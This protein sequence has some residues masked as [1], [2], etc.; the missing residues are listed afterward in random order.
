M[1]YGEIIND[2]DH[3]RDELYEHFYKYFNNPTMFKIKDIN[4]YSMYITKVHCLLNNNFR[5]IIVFV[6][7]DNEQVMN[8]QQLSQLKWENIQTRTLEDYHN[9][10]QHKY[11]PTRN[12]ELYT[13]IQRTLKDVDKSVYSCKK[14]PLLITL[15]HNK[16]GANQYQDTGNVVTALETYNTLVSIQNVEI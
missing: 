13:P 16:G 3:E 8:Q 9:I 7:K 4:D 5:Y 6:F 12:T 10:P 14:Y 1:N 2:F 15:L 11:Q